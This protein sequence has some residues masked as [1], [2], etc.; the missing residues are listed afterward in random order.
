MRSTP[1]LRS[2][3]DV[4]FETVSMFVWLTMAFSRP[5]KEDR[6]GSL[7]PRLSP[8]GD[9]WCDVP[10]FVP[11]GSVS[12]SSTL[13]RQFEFLKLFGGGKEPWKYERHV[14]CFI[15][16]SSL[17]SFSG[18]S[19]PLGDMAHKRM[20][21]LPV[22]TKRGRWTQKTHIPSRVLFLCTYY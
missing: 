14:L 6:L 4:A 16:N 18:L 7:L 2:F 10:G 21:W 17:L 13:A 22:N 11:A 5:F 19:A 12:S 1:S 8:P 9:R 3:P 15:L 20:H